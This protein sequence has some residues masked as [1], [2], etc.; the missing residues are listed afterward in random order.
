MKGWICKTSE[1]GCQLYKQAIVIFGGERELN[2]YLLISLGLVILGG[3]ILGLLKKVVVFR[4]YAD[5]STVVTSL[6]APPAAIAIATFL[7]LKTST[8]AFQGAKWVLLGIEV[9]LV[10]R[11][12]WGTWR[13][14]RSLWKLPIALIT[15]YA[16][17]LAFVATFMALITGGDS[18]KRG[19]SYSDYRARNEHSRNMLLGLLAMVSGLIAL[20][21]R[22]QEFSSSAAEY[23]PEK[24]FI[25]QKKAA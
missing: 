25:N 10:L 1:A 9:I 24:E 13:D 20:L 5:V 14:N 18:R 17:C 15:K 11:T 6:A 8:M 3:I 16:V 22:D 12:L 7:G 2:K 23:N 4:D 19:E 21:V